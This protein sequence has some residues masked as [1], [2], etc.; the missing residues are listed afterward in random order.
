M[1]EIMA[2]FPEPY[3]DEDFRSV[4]YRYHIRSGNKKFKESKLDLFNVS[5]HKNIYFPCNYDYF[6]SKISHKTHFKLEKLLNENTFFP[7]FK[8]FITLKRYNLLLSSIRQD[9]GNKKLNLGNLFGMKQGRII[10]GNIRYC[11]MCISEDFKKYGEVYVH[12]I[13]Q[14]GFID[15]CYTHRTQLISQCPKCKEELSAS[16]QTR[17]ISSPNCLSG[18]RIFDNEID[19]NEMNKDS[20][21]KLELLNH[22]YMLLNFE[23]SISRESFLIQIA[24]SLGEAGYVDN[25]GKFK[26]I[27][28]LEDLL[29]KFS[30][31][32]MTK[33]GLSKEYIS[34][35]DVFL[36]LLSREIIPDIRLY[37]I[38]MMFLG[39]DIEGIIEKESS[40]FS[41]IGRREL[42]ESKQQIAASVDSDKG[43]SLNVLTRRTK[44]N[45]NKYDK[46]LSERVETAFIDLYESN[47]S[48]PI[49]KWSVIGTLPTIDQ[50]RIRRKLEKLPLTEEVFKRRVE[51]I[52]DF[53]IRKL[54]YIIKK[55]EDKG[56]RNITYKS[57]CYELPLYQ[58]CSNEVKEYIIKELK[59]RGYQE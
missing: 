26:R 32:D 54:P 20:K 55:Q 9:K 3:E 34:S 43:T 53:Q 58:K 28:L 56:L 4:I 44:I 59:E 52:Q 45:W 25:N 33:V 13:H 47:P 5:S 41:H 8:P 21:F 2:F 42:E 18:H 1:G 30:I 6:E 38:L 40:H 24:K 15:H 35:K 29:Q 39:I 22:F 11:P 50:T 31:D 12:R 17:L 19:V 49:K 48:K 37:I 46:E 7:L 51:K 57:I 36:H 23:T 10:S 16:N 14:F 27:K